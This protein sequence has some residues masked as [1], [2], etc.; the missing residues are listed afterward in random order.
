MLCGVGQSAMLG[1]HVVFAYS[2]MGR[3]IVLYVTISV[4]LDL[5]QCV[6]VSCLSMLVDFLAFCVVFDMCWL[7]VSFVSNVRPSIFGV[8]VT[9]SGVLFI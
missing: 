3:M 2:S 8:C 9:G 6:V 5:P 7:Y 1:V 4:S